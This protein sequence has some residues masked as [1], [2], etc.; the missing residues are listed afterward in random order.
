MHVVPLALRRD[1]LDVLASLAN[2]PGAFLLEVPDPERPVTLLGCAPRVQLRVGADGRAERSDGVPAGEDP[3][4]AIERFVAE[5]GRGS[6]DSP[7]PLGGNVVGFLGYELGQFIERPRDRA[8]LSS[9]L[10]LA[11]LSRYDAVLAYDQRRAQYTLVA[12]DGGE[13]PAPWLERLAA[14]LPPVR[15]EGPL[16][17]T[18]LA[19]LLPREQYLAAVRCILDYLAAGDV[20]QVNLTQPFVA[21]LAAPPWALFARLA[22]RH[23]V[24]Y[25][26]YL[27]I[28][29]AQLVANSP[30]LFLRRRGARVETRPIKGTRPRGEWAARDAALAAELLRD[31]KERAEHV[32]IVDLERNDLGRVCVAGSVAVEGLAR[33]ES[34]PTVHHLVSTVTGRLRSGVGLAELLRATFPGGSITGAPKVRAMEII[35]ELEPGPRGPYT[36]A[37]GLFHAGG[38]LEL[39]LAIRTAVVRGSTVRYHAGGG[40][41]ADS[42]AERE[43]AETWLKTAALRLALGEEPGTA[44]ERCSSG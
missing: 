18:P 31:P 41:V 17:T 26:A 16:A 2:E 35:R 15:W 22:R 33:V 12:H 10:P 43:L 39:G 6:G 36:G 38:D 13:P 32:M 5:T 25:G 37:F 21:P 28:G 1:P 29:G 7:F 24:P 11:V 9:D 23:P 4:A 44:L 30:E 27:D 34:H 14:P 3:L 19:P 42:D 8:A 40:I 20:Y